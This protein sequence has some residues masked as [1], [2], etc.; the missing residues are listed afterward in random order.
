MNRGTKQLNDEVA[1]QNA[2]TKKYYVSVLTNQHN[3]KHSL[4]RLQPRRNN[5]NL[6]I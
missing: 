3:E 1:T 4:I 6:Y 5:S 2:P